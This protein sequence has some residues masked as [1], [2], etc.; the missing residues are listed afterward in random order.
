M[1]TE[2]DYEPPELFEY[3]DFETITRGGSGPNSDGTGGSSMSKG[4]GN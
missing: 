1:Q 4:K 3:G 2:Q